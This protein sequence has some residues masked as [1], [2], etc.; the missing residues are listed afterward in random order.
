MPDIPN[1]TPDLAAAQRAF[2]EFVERIPQRARI[3]ALHGQA[4]GGSLPVARWNE[5]LQKL[6]FGKEVE[7]AQ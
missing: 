4:S 2:Q 7:A 3:A 5:L 1:P 6:G